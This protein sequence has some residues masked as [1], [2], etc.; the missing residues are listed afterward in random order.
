MK[1]LISI[2]A[3][4]VLSGCGMMAKLTAAKPDFPPPYVDEKTNKMPTCD[5]LKTIPPDVNNLSSIFKIVAENYTAYW[6][7]SNKVDGWKEWYDT[8]KRNYEK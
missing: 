4:F 3:S 5:D 6:Q 8:Q 2:L 1:V 7:C